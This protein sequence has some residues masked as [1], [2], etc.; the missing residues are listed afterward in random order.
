M[1]GVNNEGWGGG[2]G[3]RRVAASPSTAAVWLINDIS[4][5]GKV[6]KRRKEKEGLKR[7]R[8]PFFGK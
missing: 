2:R 3:E 6:R 4:G 5:G 8:M 7:R 1:G